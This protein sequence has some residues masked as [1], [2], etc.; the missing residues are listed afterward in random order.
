MSFNITT[1]GMSPSD[2][3]TVEIG[4]REC[5][6]IL[7]ALSYT[8]GEKFTYQPGF[9][10]KDVQWAFKI[11]LMLMFETIDTGFYITSIIPTDNTGFLIEMCRIPAS[12]DPN[13]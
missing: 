11:S 6:V 1:E 3:A 9:P 4:V 12:T 2:K 7:T 8:K 10:S 5:N 13:E